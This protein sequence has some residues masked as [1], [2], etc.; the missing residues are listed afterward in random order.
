VA[1][2]AR[3]GLA[4]E[5]ATRRT[6]SSTGLRPSQRQLH[7]GAERDPDFVESVASRSRRGSRFHGWSGD[8]LAVGRTDPRPEPVGSPPGIEGGDPSS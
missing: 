1:R 7:R 6:R 8:L 3:A 2:H 5:V 4:H